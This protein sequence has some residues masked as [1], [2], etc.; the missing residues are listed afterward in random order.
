MQITFYS[1]DKDTH[2]RLVGAARYDDTLAGIENALA[3][4]LNMSV[5]TPLC[6]ANRDY[7]K[8]LEFLHGKGVVYVTCSGLI[9]TGNATKPESE[10]MQLSADEIKEILS[11]AVAFC[12]A[13]GMEISYTS[14]GWV[15]PGFCNS[16]GLNDPC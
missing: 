11:D 2:N 4:G 7:V 5:N 10:R 8:T 12:H 14:P 3:A 15:E 13:H 6:T 9:E 16:L 1:S